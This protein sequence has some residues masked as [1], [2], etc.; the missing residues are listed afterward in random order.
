[1]KIRISFS[2]LIISALFILSCAGIEYAV[3][4]DSIT[5]ESVTSEANAESFALFAEDENSLPLPEINEEESE[6]EGSS[7]IE[8]ASDPQIIDNLPEP[9]IPLQG[10]NISAEKGSEA[11]PGFTADNSVSQPEGPDITSS[12]NSSSSAESPETLYIIADGKIQILDSGSDSFQKD[13]GSAALI[14]ESMISSPK[15]QQT[16]YSSGSSQDPG[17]GN[18]PD[19]N[20]AADTFSAESPENVSWQVNTEGEISLAGRGWYFISADKPEMLSFDRR[21][22]DGDG[23]RFFFVPFHQGTVLLYFRRQDV[24][25]EDTEDK[26]VLASIGPQT[27][28]NKEEQSGSTGPE[29]YPSNLLSDN[30]SSDSLAAPDQPADPEEY[31]VTGFSFDLSAFDGMNKQE[32]IRIIENYINHALIGEAIILAEFALDELFPDDFNDDL[33]WILATLYEMD[34]P[35]KNLKTAISFYRQLAENY[36]FSIHYNAAN[37]RIGFLERFHVFY[38]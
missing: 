36:P 17:N 8:T 10:I 7:G 26:F 32:I 34:S 20:L 13:S 19:S 33:L 11:L 22:I 27:A 9:E 38:K 15:D 16:L 28:Y 25:E 4:A 12:G 31:P 30:E 1:M 3:E 29:I 18:S 21:I 37:E 24:Y 14:K 23:T 2:I 5:A 6:G 35:Y